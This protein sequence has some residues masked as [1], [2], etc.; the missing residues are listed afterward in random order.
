MLGDENDVRWAFRVG[1][2][3][4]VISH[5]YRMIASRGERGAL[6]AVREIIN[7]SRCD[8][9]SVIVVNGIHILEFQISP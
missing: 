8:K 3:G 9:G 7:N 5:I 2:R 6:E 1:D 4:T